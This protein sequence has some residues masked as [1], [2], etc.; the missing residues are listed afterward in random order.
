M[1]WPNR[2]VIEPDQAN[3]LY[4][5]V[6]AELIYFP[7]RRREAENSAYVVAELVNWIPQ[8][9]HTAVLAEPIF[10]AE[11]QRGGEFS[12]QCFSGISKTYNFPT[13]MP[14]VFSTPVSDNEVSAIL[15][16]LLA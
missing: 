6:V 7:Q 11:T 3:L 4:A 16:P 14:K 5:T 13:Q 9:R 1:Y 10:L 15:S 8:I 2:F 12:L